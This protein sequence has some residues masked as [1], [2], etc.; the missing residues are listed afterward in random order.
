MPQKGNLDFSVH[1]LCQYRGYVD[2]KRGNDLRQVVQQAASKHL[3]NGKNYAPTE[4]FTTGRWELKIGIQKTGK[5][6][7]KD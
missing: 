6:E 2:A 7:V 1:Q 4:D 3:I 5:A